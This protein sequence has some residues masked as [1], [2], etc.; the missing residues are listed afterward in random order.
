M[1]N[2]DEV[3]KG[4]YTASTEE[5]DDDDDEDFIG[6]S[7][8]EELFQHQDIAG[9]GKGHHRL[10]IVHPDVKWGRRKQY[11]TTGEG[12]GHPFFFKPIL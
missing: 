6:D 5:E 3:S 12:W 10:F 9:V 1:R 7:E 11:L 4:L 8:V 2:N